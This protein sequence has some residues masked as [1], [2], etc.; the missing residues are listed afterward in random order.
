MFW[1]FSFG[2]V[3]QHFLFCCKLNFFL[4]PLHS[5]S[6]R[7]A[8]SHV[9]DP[10]YT[11]AYQFGCL[12]CAT[13]SI[14]SFHL[15]ISSRVG[16][17]CTHRFST[18]TFR[19]LVLNDLQLLVSLRGFSCNRHIVEFFQ[20]RAIF[21]LCLTTSTTDGDLKLQLLQWIGL[22]W[23]LILFLCFDVYLICG[24]LQNFSCRYHIGSSF[25]QIAALRIQ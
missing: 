21:F 2:Y 16:N 19:D 9:F 3:F 1:F 25:P 14:V 8:E 10:W 5:H 7:S 23:V 13:E 17:T 12:T 24:Y 20:I 4:V 6:R 18:E 15:L 22:F 11:K